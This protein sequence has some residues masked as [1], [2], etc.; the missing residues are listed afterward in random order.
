M[1]E[2][3]RLCYL[4]LL[5]IIACF[6]VILNHTQGYIDCFKYSGEGLS[7]TLM[8]HLFVGMIVKVN[9][10]VFFMI[11]GTLMLS[12]DIKAGKLLK[13][14]VKFFL[15][16]LGFSLV[17]NFAYSG[18]IYVPGFIRNFASA[19]VDGAG[20]YWYLYSYLG[21]LLIAVFLRYVT[22]NMTLKDTYY[23]IALRFLLTGLVP[24]VFL[25]LNGI[26]DSNIHLAS[27]F[28]PAIVLCDCI[29]YTLIGFGVDRLFDIRKLG[30]FGVVLT[31]FVFIFTALLESVLTMYAGIENVF[32]GFDFVMTISLFLVV[33]YLLTENTISEKAQRAV[34]T[35]GKLTFGIYLL[36]PVI[37]TVLKP[38]VHSLYP[39]IPSMLA[40]SFLYCLVSMI[41]GG[42]LT[43]IWME[44][45]YW[46]LLKITGTK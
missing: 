1:G 42:I 3:K 14:T 10:P 20:A 36:D 19:D 16:L 22:K 27:E 33:K 23:L 30:G 37:G 46:R 9:V 26:M 4:D 43:Y 24:M 18:H 25:V 13:K 38:A 7:L 31:V 34:S 17:A 11:T 41:C 15:I 39:K 6:L 45:I 21:I 29:F 5:R 40:V 28:N 2:K 12:G 44:G 8:W 32:S 35:V